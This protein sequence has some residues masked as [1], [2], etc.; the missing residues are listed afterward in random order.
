MI[1]ERKETTDGFEMQFGINHLGHFY[2]TSKLWD[3]LKEAKDPRIINVSSKA[4]ERVRL[5]PSKIVNF[6]WKNLNFDYDYDAQMAYSRSKLAN[7]LFT[8]ELARK[9]SDVLP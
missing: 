7:V 8:Q 3:M 1:P 2:L 6:D 5:S 9:L 4:H